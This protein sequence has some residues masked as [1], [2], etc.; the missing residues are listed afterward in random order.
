[1]LIQDLTLGSL[2]MSDGVSWRFGDA[3]ISWPLAVI[4]ARLGDFLVSGLELLSEL[5]DGFIS[6]A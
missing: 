2:M 3:V 1:M 6:V 5:D 4:S